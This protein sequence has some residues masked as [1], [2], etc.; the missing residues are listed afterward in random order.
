[1]TKRSPAL[2]LGSVLSL[3][4]QSLF[5]H[6][7]P[8][9][10]VVREVEIVVNMRP[11]RPNPDRKAPKVK[12]KRTNNIADFQSCI[13]ILSF[14]GLTLALVA[15]GDVVIGFVHAWAHQVRHACV[16]TVESLSKVI[17]LHL[18]KHTW[19]ATVSVALSL[20]AR[21]VRL[22]VECVVTDAPHCIARQGI[23]WDQSRSARFPCTA[24]VV[25]RCRSY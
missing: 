11:G 4:N 15:H 12:E 6:N 14:F 18:R 24:R 17:A 9:H 16:D 22:F 8:E 7:V 10:I 20:A 13:C 23:H 5:S 21:D 2:A 1:M 19:A 3:A 25:H